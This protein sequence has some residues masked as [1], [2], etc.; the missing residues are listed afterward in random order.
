MKKKNIIKFFRKIINDGLEFDIVNGEY[1]EIISYI[2]SLSKR[3]LII[4]LSEQIKILWLYME[5]IG[6]S[7]KDCLKFFEENKEFI[8]SQINSNLTEFLSSS[9]N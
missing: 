1:S 6:I 4:W 9:I 5:Y 3:D 2:K 7:K 8:V